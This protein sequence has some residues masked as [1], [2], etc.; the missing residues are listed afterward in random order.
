MDGTTH[1]CKHG[2]KESENDSGDAN[3]RGEAKY[4]PT[5]EERLARLEEAVFGNTE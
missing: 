4:A 5:V 3:N 2:G 1:D